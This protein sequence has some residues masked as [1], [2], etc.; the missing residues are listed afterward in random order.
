M[1]SQLSF[2]KDYHNYNRQQF[3]TD[4]TKMGK[5]VGVE[6]GKVGHLL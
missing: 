4:T 5:G 6:W 3:S 1:L 2:K